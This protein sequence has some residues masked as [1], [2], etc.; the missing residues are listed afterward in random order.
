MEN[1]SECGYLEERHFTGSDAYSQFL[2]IGKVHKLHD[3]GS[4]VHCERRGE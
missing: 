2:R 3:A 4:G 1:Q